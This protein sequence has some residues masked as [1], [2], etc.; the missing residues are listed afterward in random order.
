[1][2]GHSSAEL[3]VKI[4]ETYHEAE[5]RTRVL[6][7]VTELQRRYTQLLDASVKISVIY[8]SAAN[9]DKQAYDFMLQVNTLATN[10][11]DAMTAWITEETRAIDNLLKRG[12]RLSDEIERL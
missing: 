8:H 3:A 2:S 5:E 10:K 11:I 6:A 7:T 12:A 1:M 4:T 9:Y